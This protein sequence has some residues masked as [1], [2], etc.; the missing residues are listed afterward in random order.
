MVSTKQQIKE[1]CL[2][3][4]PDR[5]VS[6]ISAEA[7]GIIGASAPGK[8]PR[9]VK[10][11]SKFKRKRTFQ[12]RSLKLASN[13]ADDLFAVVQQAYSDDPSHKFV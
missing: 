4:G 12:S 13:A 8:L 1:E 6:S 3:R 7:G 2:V 5:T 9:N 11:I 10:Q